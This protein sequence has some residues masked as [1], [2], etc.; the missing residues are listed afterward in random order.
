[1]FSLYSTA[2]SIDTCELSI[3]KSQHSLQF[4][5]EDDNAKSR[6]FF[7]CKSP[8]I[9]WLFVGSHKSLQ[10]CENLDVCAAQFDHG[11]RQSLRALVLEAV[12]VKTILP[13][14]AIVC[15]II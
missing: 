7:F 1:M 13:L 12:C 8:D 15:V 14:V 9:I 11:R 2:H 6:G 5:T 10:F 4:A 3:K